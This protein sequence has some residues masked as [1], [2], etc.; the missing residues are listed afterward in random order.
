MCGI[1]GFV[2][3]SRNASKIDHRGLAD[4]MAVTL[5]H[6]GPDDQGVWI[7]AA[8]GIGLVHRRLAIIDLSPAGHQPMRSASGRYCVCFNGE[9]YNFLEL[10]K[11]LRDLGHE[12]RGRSDTEVLLAAME[13]WG[14]DAASSRLSGMFAFALW[15]R[16]D[17]ILHL[18]RDRVGEKPL[19][20]GWA[21]NLFVFG[22]E[23]KALRAAP[24]W[25]GRID[26]A[27][28]ALQMRYGYIP[29][30]WSIYSGIFKLPPGC[31][32]SLVTSTLSGPSAICPD[33]DEAAPGM[34]APRRYWSARSVA[35]SATR[36][37]SLVEATDDLDAI[38]L[39]VV[40]QQMLA[41]VPL[42]AFLS[43][44]IDSSTVV[45]CMQAQSARPIKT[46]TIGY[47]EGDFNEAEH[48]LAV[49]RHLGTDHTELYIDPGQVRD[50]IPMMPELYDEPFSD[51]S[52]LPTYLICKLAR[53]H[54]TVCL[55][56]DGGDE[57]F[58]GYNRYKW[59]RTVWNGV[60]WIPLPTRRL[61]A[62]SLTALP[63]ATWDRLASRW[64]GAKGAE[65]GR[66]PQ[67][68][69]KLHK[70]GRAI[71]A[72]S[73]G[74]MYE[75]L[76]SYWA[77]DPSIVRDAADW[78]SRLCGAV[79]LLGGTADAVDEAMY[80]DL[81]QYL[82]DDNLV[83]VDRASMRVGLEVRAPLLDPRIVEYAWS[84]PRDM[85]IHGGSGKWILRQVL[86]RY[87]PPA[88]TERPKMGFSVPIGD[89]LRGEL[90][91]WAEEMLGESRL[92]EEGY[93][94]VVR[95]RR[96]WSEHLSGERDHSLSLW[97]V[98]MFETWYA[99]QRAVQSDRHE[100]AAAGSPASALRRIPPG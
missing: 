67:L 63:P 11:E 42:G 25:V 80:R 86:A 59:L 48:A 85:K 36:S 34:T 1:A 89:W 16:K 65:H 58:G 51:A 94:D 70:L 27:S 30:P 3:P 84:L 18:V 17:G 6:R 57:V 47:Q 9:I 38:L 55:S 32:L 24:A 83:K 64:W 98:L 4:S 60:R 39:K 45:A 74:Q 97:A 7:D 95:V 43:G 21:G 93:L 26:R 62:R 12:F 68:G 31:I 52:Q 13:Q 91:P 56:G 82:P 96:R 35:Q 75:S 29:G 49:A 72:R 46:Y 5:A 76:V 99:Q 41:D 23:L 19:Y 28:L 37:C 77:D 14:V 69:N 78:S 92:Q 81:R 87:V 66:L 54:V 71:E 88:L 22:S 20:Y 79:D 100:I 90:R 53:Q 61:F 2:D 73:V 50:V 40:G 8:V 33:P 10:M 15:D 44:G